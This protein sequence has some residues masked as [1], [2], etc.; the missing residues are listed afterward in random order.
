MRRRSPALL[1]AAA[2]LLAGCGSGDGGSSASGG[3]DPVL[4]G[5]PVIDDIERTERELSWDAVDGAASYRVA[6]LGPGGRSLWAGSSDEAELTVPAHVQ[7][8]TDAEL[9]VSALDGD[10]HAV[11]AGRAGN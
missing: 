1:L 10:G 9:V 4:R 5:V 11:A 7:V 6:L 3:D 8:P 2:A